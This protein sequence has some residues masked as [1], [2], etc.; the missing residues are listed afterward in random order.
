MAQWHVTIPDEADL[1]VRQYLDESG[2]D[3]SEYVNR[4]VQSD[5]LRRI[6]REIQEQNSDLSAEGAQALADE[7]VAWARASRT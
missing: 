6:I 5:L 1:Q 2:T 7:A 3:L 4:L